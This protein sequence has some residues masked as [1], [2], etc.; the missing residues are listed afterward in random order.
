MS[1]DRNVGGTRCIP[2]QAGTGCGVL[3]DT[4][5]EG[6]GVLVLHFGVQ[7]VRPWGQ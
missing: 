5:G 4:H 7:W 6:D 1:R 3:R 2:G